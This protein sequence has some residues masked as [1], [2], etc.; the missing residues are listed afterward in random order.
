MLENAARDYDTFIDDGVPTKLK[1]YGRTDSVR[2]MV[3]RNCTI[4]VGSAQEPDKVRS[5]DISMCHLTEVGLWKDTPT[6]TP[7]DLVEAITGAILEG[8]YTLMVLESTA[9]GVGNYFHRTW[10]DAV[11]GNNSF[12]PVFVPWFMI[13]I[14]SKPINTSYESF[15]ESMDE[16]EHW[17][18]GLGATLEA[19]NW[20]RNKKKKM[21]DFRMKSE[22]PSTAE[23]AF[24]SSGAA[25]FKMQYL[26][27]LYQSCKP[28]KFVGEIVSAHSDADKQEYLQDLR[29]IK[30]PHG[31][32]K[33]WEDVDKSRP[34]LN[35]YLVTVDL[36]KGG[37]KDADS[38]IA[39]VWDRYWQKAGEDGY[40]EVVAEYAVIESETDLL[41]WRIAQ[42]AAYY[43]NA[44]LVIESNTIDSSKENR[45]RAILDEIKD[46]YPNIY[47]RAIS[48]PNDVGNTGGFRYGWNTNHSSKEEIIADL[49][50]AM[51]EGMYVERCREAVDE[52]KI[53][54]RKPNGSLGAVDGRGN[55]D[56]RVITRA[57]GIH[58]CYKKMSKPMDMEK[59]SAYTIPTKKIINEMTL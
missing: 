22:Y 5:E 9:K 18:F 28:P 24:Q 48:N 20:Y 12:T 42:I 15:I 49:D 52:M 35:R 19:I 3:G 37:S 23:E 44:L 29:F 32:L 4:S 47:K 50:W 39:C 46:Y 59:A 26:D 13:D 45:F 34:M 54:E 14:Y 58:F 55:H 56:D 51:R 21:D 53:F 25:M 7:E 38:T 17:L 27:E 11:K 31:S 33:M 40:P 10:L 1:P 57:M 36:G 6:K 30:D 43:N 2:E 8:A 16:Y 41:A